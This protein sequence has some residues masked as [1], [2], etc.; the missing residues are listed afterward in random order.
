VITYRKDLF[1]HHYIVHHHN[2]C[3]N[4]QQQQRLAEVN[5]IIAKWELKLKKKKQ[6]KP[7][8]VSGLPLCQKSI[9]YTDQYLSRKLKSSCTVRFN[10]AYE[11]SNTKCSH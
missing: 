5:R 1:K 9:K 3:I 2:I 4:N 11:T 6:K 7:L 8:K 10:D